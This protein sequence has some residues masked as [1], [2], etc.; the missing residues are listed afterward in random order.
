MAR[1]IV[2]A[3]PDQDPL[4]LQVDIGDGELAGQRHGCVVDWVSMEHSRNLLMPG[5]NRRRVLVDGG[6]VGVYVCLS[7]GDAWWEERAGN[8]GF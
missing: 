2:T 3:Y 1:R 8:A 5:V 6:S 7:T 4:A